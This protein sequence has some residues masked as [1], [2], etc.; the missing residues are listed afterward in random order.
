MT[1]ATAITV[2]IQKRY[3]DDAD[4]KPDEAAE[5]EHRLYN[6]DDETK[7]AALIMDD[8]FRSARTDERAEARIRANH[9][10]ILQPMAQ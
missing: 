5:A 8:M 10:S 7:M 4:A 6:C 1:G 2:A 3:L 9:S